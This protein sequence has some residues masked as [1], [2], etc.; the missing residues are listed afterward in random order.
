MLV[1]TAWVPR[2]QGAK[3][4][5]VSYLSHQE[6]SLLGTSIAVA[7]SSLHIALIP[8]F[9]FHVKVGKLRNLLDH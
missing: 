9:A 7:N 3:V 1:D 2:C 8:N 5:P 4:E 6:T